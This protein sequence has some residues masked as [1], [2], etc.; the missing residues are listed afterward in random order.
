MEGMGEEERNRKKI[1]LYPCAQELHQQ[2]RIY[3]SEKMLK[4]SRGQIF[5]NQS[6]LFRTGWLLGEQQEGTAIGHGHN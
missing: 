1:A 5:Q 6:G 2:N 3:R 4:G